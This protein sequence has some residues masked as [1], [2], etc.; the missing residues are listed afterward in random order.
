[1]ILDSNLERTV[2]STEEVLVPLGVP[3]KVTKSRTF[4]HT[5]ELNLNEK[6]EGQANVGFIDIISTSILKNIERQRGR[7]YKESETTSYEIELN[8]ETAIKYQLIWTDIWRRGTVQIPEMQNASASFR[9]R[10]RTEL[11]VRAV[12]NN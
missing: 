11:E 10:E 1:M 3:I 8:G 12:G 2:A 4:E 6:L 5:I 9:F 7:G